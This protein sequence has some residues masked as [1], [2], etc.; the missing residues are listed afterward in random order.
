M[1]HSIVDE[2]FRTTAFVWFK[3]GCTKWT[4]L[5]KI[6]RVVLQSSDASSVTSWHSATTFP[7]LTCNQLVC[8]IVD[9]NKMCMISAM[10][11]IAVAHYIETLL[12]KNQYP[13]GIN[14]KQRFYHSPAPNTSQAASMPR[15][16]NSNDSVFIR[17]AF[18]KPLL[19][20]LAPL[21]KIV[22]SCFRVKMKLFGPCQVSDSKFQYTN[23]TKKAICKQNYP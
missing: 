19:K 16:S 2:S 15:F 5:P 3:H 8:C 20:K 18:E 9:R 17:F 14:W 6:N 4:V 23:W 10:H 7:L 21:G 22:S 12:S 1:F 11:L 13:M